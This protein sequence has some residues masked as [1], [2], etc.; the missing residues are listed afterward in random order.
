MATY[1]HNWFTSETQ[2]GWT[3]YTLPTLRD[4]VRP[5]YDSAKTNNAPLTD[6]KLGRDI[7]TCPFIVPRRKRDGF[8][9][10]VNWEWK[11]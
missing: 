7:R 3:T 11:D 4:A 1:L 9:Y 2:T 8:V 10:D 5:F 6:T